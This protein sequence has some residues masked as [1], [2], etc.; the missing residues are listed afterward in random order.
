MTNGKIDRKYF[1]LIWLALLVACFMRNSYQMYL[2]FSAMEDVS[3]LLIIRDVFISIFSYGV[4]PTAVVF[5]LALITWQIGFSRYVRCISRND[6][7]YTVMS[8]TAGVYFTVGLI[9][10]FSIL[11]P[12]ISAVSSTVLEPALLMGAFLAMFFFIFAKMHRFNP[13]EKYNAFRAWSIVFMV[14]TGLSAIGGNGMILMLAADSGLSV[15]ILLRLKE[16]GYGIFLSEVQV[17]C[18]IAAICIYVAYLVA[19]IVIGEIMRSRANKFRNPETRGEY[20]SQYDGRAY[21]VRNDAERVFEEES[22]KHSAE[23]RKEDNVFEEFDL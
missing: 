8:V 19:F 3:R 4:I 11:S 6:F 1:V 13:V 12:E 20:Y 10:I 14:L 22:V 17:G 18:S 7:C 5:V 23:K 9:E 2:M 15:E 16:L 21:S